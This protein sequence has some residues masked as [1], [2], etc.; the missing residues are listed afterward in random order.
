MLNSTLRVLIPILVWG[1]LGLWGLAFSALLRSRRGPIPLT[2]TVVFRAIACGPL[3]FFL[4][5][6]KATRSDATRARKYGDP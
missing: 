6:R 2:P 4:D 5:W 1:S 3:S